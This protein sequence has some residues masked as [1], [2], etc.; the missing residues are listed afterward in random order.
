M[1]AGLADKPIAG[2]SD[3][4]PALPAALPAGVEPNTNA[5]DAIIARMQRYREH[6]WAAIE[7]GIIWTLDSAKLSDPRGVIKPFPQHPWLR[8]MTDEWLKADPPL[9]ACPK[10]RRMTMSWLAIW[11]HLW[12]TMF[13]IGSHVYCQSLN[14]QLANDE[15]IERAGF[16]YNHIPDSAFP[17]PR[18][19]HDRVSW[20][21][22]SFPKLYSFMRGVPQGANQLRGPTATAVLMDEAAFWEKGRESF[23]ATKPATEG[24]G[25]VTV[26]SSAQLGWYRDLCFDEIE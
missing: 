2:Y 21:L 11:W 14:E 3:V 25:R 18:L 23:G 5:A 22:I 4:A 16:I 24:G 1:V 19:K 20:C 17:K 7:D 8:E 15:I 10:S 12:L 13:F 6:P 26:I 9:F